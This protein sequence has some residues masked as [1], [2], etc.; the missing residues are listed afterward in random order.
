MRIAVLNF[1]GVP[2]VDIKDSTL[3]KADGLELGLCLGRIR[4][5]DP[6][7]PRLV[8]VLHPDPKKKEQI[9]C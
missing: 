8:R 7:N 4:E 1:T 2:S 5:E 3:F 6:E 9:H